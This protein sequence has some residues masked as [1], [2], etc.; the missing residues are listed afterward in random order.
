M[1]VHLDGR[2]EYGG[3]SGLQFTDR[4]WTVIGA[5]NAQRMLGAGF[6]TVRNLGGT[7]YNVI[8]LDQVIEEGWMEGPRIVGR[9]ACA[10]CDRRAL[11][12]TLSSRP[13]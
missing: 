13:A 7:D 8:G 4:F 9:C 11:R 5:V 1:H 2:P 3:Y 12:Q 6:T 10:G